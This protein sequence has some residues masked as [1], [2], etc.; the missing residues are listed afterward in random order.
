MLVRLFQLIKGYALMFHP[1]MRFKRLRLFRNSNTYTGG[2]SLNTQQIPECQ[3]LLEAAY[4]EYGVA[5]SGTN[6]AAGTIHDIRIRGRLGQ[7]RALPLQSAFQ[8][9]LS[10]AKTAQA[11]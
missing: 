2:N 5:V 9:F 8:P 11:Q 6:H 1:G 3:R 10:L 4:M 7:S